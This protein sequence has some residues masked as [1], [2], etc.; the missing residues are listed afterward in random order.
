MSNRT[1]D[2]RGEKALGLF[3]DH[4]FY[5]R[6]C[7]IEGFIGTQR[8]YAAEEQ[9]AGI[10]LLITNPSGATLTIDEKAQLHYINEPCPTFAFEISF[11]NENTRSITDGWFV[12]DSNRSACYILVWI[13]DARTS[14]VNRLVEEDFTA[15]TVLL[16][17]KKNIIQYLSKLGYPINRIKTLAEELRNRGNKNI[18]RLSPNTILYFSDAGY[19]EKPI[20]VLIDK[21]VLCKMAYGVY[22]VT[23]K[24]CQKL[25]K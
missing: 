15:V 22:N 12:N 3:L 14:Q 7:E 25:P 11:Y 1:N 21:A 18:Y 5:P 10:D 2:I 13:D 20:N 8:I 6:L 17:T 23:R 16:I 4:Y 9:K 24:D 19:D